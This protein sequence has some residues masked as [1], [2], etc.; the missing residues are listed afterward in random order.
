MRVS[1]NELFSTL[2]LCSTSGAELTNTKKKLRF[3]NFKIHADAIIR[4][5]NV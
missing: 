2:K 3:R 1:S 5:T 4:R